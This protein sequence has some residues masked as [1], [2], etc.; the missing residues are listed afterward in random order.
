V[1]DAELY[2]RSATD[3]NTRNLPPKASLS[4]RETKPTKPTQVADRSLTCRF[5][6]CG[7]AGEDGGVE[8]RAATCESPFWC[9]RARHNGGIHLRSVWFLRTR[10]VRASRRPFAAR[11]SRLRSCLCDGECAA[12]FN[13]CGGQVTDSPSRPAPRKW[14]WAIDHGPR[15]DQRHP[16]MESLSLPNQP[17]WK[18][19][20]DYAPSMKSPLPT[21][22]LERDQKLHS[23]DHFRKN[24]EITVLPPLNSP[25]SIPMRFNIDPERPAI[26]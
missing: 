26:R 2:V 20:K 17:A 22:W 4:A 1:E 21:R 24:H 11:P 6:A 12:T 16:T 25:S 7:D 10:N 15:P 19:F 8:A 9:R 5:S 14:P 13:G 3:V 23:S 18:E